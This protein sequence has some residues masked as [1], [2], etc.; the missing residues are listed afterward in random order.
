MVA[1]LL[2]VAGCSN[3]ESESAINDMPLSDIMTSLY[4]GIAEDELPMMGEAVS[5]TDE[6]VNWYLG[7]D[8][9]DFKEALA[10]ESM[11]SSVAHSVVLVRANDD[12]DIEALKTAIK[13]SIDTN[14]WICVGIDKSE[15]V[16]ESKGNV[17]LVVVVQDV[18]TRD[19]I[20]TNF[21]KL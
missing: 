10:M 19:E 12:Q 8:S 1:C 9:C 17:I 21:E 4:E 18:A 5:V 6:N 20:A 14:K 11:I 2:L 15:M 7:L 16:L 13:D 3:K